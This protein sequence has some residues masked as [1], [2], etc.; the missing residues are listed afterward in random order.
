MITFKNISHFI[1]SLLIGHSN[2]QVNVYTKD[3]K[4]DI[5]IIN[6]SKYDTNRLNDIPS[7]IKLISRV[8]LNNLHIHEYDLIPYDLLE[9]TFNI[10]PYSN[11]IN[12]NIINSI[13]V[14]SEFEFLMNDDNVY[15]STYDKY[16]NGIYN[17]SVT[18]VGILEI[19]SSSASRIKGKYDKIIN[20]DLITNF[21]YN[22]LKSIIA[23]HE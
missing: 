8:K 13:N 23:Y 9:F 19:L 11:L 2:I 6:N 15:L 3:S 4:S 20:P 16:Y 18:I 5:L 12:T 22:Q 14:D 7:H 17:E 21:K 10:L 1:E